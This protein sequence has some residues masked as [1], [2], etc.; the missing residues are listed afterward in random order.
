VS[1]EELEPR[2][3]DQSDHQEVPEEGQTRRTFLR[4]AVVGSALAATAVG[5]GA[6]VVRAT[7]LGPRLLGSVQ[8]VTDQVSG[9]VVFDPCFE[10]TNFISLSSFNVHNGNASPGSFFLWFT[11]YNLPAGTYTISISP[12]PGDATTPFKLADAGNGAFLFK[13]A[14]NTASQC[15]SS[16]P[17]DQVAAGHTVDDVFPYTFTGANSDLQLKVHLAYDGGT[18]T[19]DATYSY[20]GTLQNGAH[21]TLASSTISITAHPV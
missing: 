7:P 20:T 6:A 17:T 1:Q 18:L 15:P 3:Q 10:D 11:A 21:V 2:N 19:S 14:A 12:D 13:L 8:P 9:Q 16:D 5:A 4:A